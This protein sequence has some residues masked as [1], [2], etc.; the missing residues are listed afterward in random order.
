[1]DEDAYDID[2]TNPPITLMLPRSASTDPAESEEAVFDDTEEPE[3]NDDDENIVIRDEVTPL[4]IRS[5]QMAW[6]LWNLILSLAG[7]VLAL[8]M[9]IR[10]LIKIRHEHKYNKQGEVHHDENERDRRKRLLLIL[11]IPL[12]ALAGVY[13]F[14]TTQDIRLFMIMIDWWTLAH[15]VL[16]T[17]AILCYIFVLKRD[18]DEEDAEKARHKLQVHRW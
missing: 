15:V 12:N 16:L 11:V 9:C 5:R 7:I 1:L 6:A 4:A 17:G 8:M 10:L 18:K 3:E 13:L 2:D 14:I